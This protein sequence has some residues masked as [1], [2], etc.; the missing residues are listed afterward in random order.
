MH[1]PDS[2]SSSSSTLLG[3]SIYTLIKMKCKTKK[4]EENKGQC[5]LVQQQHI[6]K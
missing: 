1:Y 5:Q 6:K 4:L 2:S 3:I